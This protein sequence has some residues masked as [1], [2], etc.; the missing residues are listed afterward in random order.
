MKLRQKWISVFLALL[1][2]CST[3]G[4][5]TAAYAA[6][7]GP[8][9]DMVIYVTVVID[10]N[11]QT[12]GD[13]KAMTRRPVV[14]R[15]EDGD[16]KVTVLE[17]LEQ[18]H[19]KY[20]PGGLMT[21][22]EKCGPVLSRLWGKDVQSSGFYVN[23]DRGF[24]LRD[25]LDFYDDLYVYGSSGINEDRYAYFAQKDAQTVCLREYHIQLFQKVPDENG[26]LQEEPL[27]NAEIYSLSPYGEETDTQYHTDQNGEVD[28]IFTRSGDYFLTAKTKDGQTLPPIARITVSNG[29]LSYFLGDD[30]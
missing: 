15:D 13:K 19:E 22:S 24:A 25:T 17:A 20:C 18:V 16:G 5:S 28:L 4:F 21:R 3:F 7:T 10:Q 30:F 6:E 11:F 14:V 27:K 29:M 12:A 8:Q 2:V 26:R 9:K 1:F 23:N